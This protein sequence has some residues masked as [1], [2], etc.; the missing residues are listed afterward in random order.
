MGAL[1]VIRRVISFTPFESSA[2]AR[3]RLVERID[4]T[5]VREMRQSSTETRL[6]VVLDRTSHGNILGVPFYSEAQNDP[7]KLRQLEKFFADLAQK[8]TIISDAEF[9]NALTQGRKSRVN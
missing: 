6:E 3:K 8:A 9:S 4:S 1:S 5:V 7:E 2:P